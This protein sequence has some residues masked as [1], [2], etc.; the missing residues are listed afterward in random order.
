MA[1]L[2]AGHGRLPTYGS[3][4]GS[5]E[6]TAGFV[7]VILGLS[8]AVVGVRL[9]MIPGGTPVLSWVLIV[10]A[11]AIV[12]LSPT[13]RPL[14]RTR[15][16]SLDLA[17]LSYLLIRALIEVFNAAD[18]A[19][20]IGS[21]RLIDLAMIYVAFFSARNVIGSSAEAVA[22]LRGFALPVALVSTLAL[23]QML[24]LP[25]AAEF[26]IAITDSSSFERR[27]S[28]G[29][30]IRATSTI[31]HH[32]QLGGYL[33]GVIAVICTDIMLTKRRGRSITLPIVLLAFAMVG[34][35]ATVTFATI[36][37]SAVIVLWTLLR[38]GI[39]PMMLLVISLIGA[40]AW[41]IFGAALE[42]RLGDQ[43]QVT[44][45]E[46]AWLPQTIGYRATI[47]VNETLPAIAERP[48][49]GWGQDVYSA[50]GNGWSMRPSQLVWSSPESEYLRVLVSGGAISLAF[51]IFLFAV[52]LGTLWR[53]NRRIH[54]SGVAT[55]ALVGFVVLLLISAIHSHFSSYGP[56]LV[57]WVLVGV[58]MSV[59]ATSRASS[60][61]TDAEPGDRE[62]LGTSATARGGRAL[63][64]SRA[65][66]RGGG[67]RPTG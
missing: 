67:R 31:G 2:I 51:Q 25:G 58:L 27:T 29:W 66:V 14:L 7:G 8:A 37:A 15:L 64:V 28:L 65:T 30:D 3:A 13:A 55:P 16:G 4:V 20:S 56:P 47:W 49:T 52:T 22:F 34:Q 53:L 57:M 40:V 1:G 35:V 48:A 39:R 41:F 17:L 6:R 19:H 32:T 11:A 38:I 54:R 43:Q 60:G 45:S 50:V 61:R 10:V 26:V 62:P 5:D 33:I 18:L 63:K 9:P 23:V 42:E 12:A 24:R 36:L 59:G 21:E 44:G 46:F